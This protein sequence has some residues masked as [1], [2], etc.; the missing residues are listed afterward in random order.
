MPSMKRSALTRA[1][2]R[3]IFGYRGHS[4]WTA[5]PGVDTENDASDEEAEGWIKVPYTPPEH[6]APMP[7][8]KEELANHTLIRAPKGAI[9]AIVRKP[10]ATAVAVIVFDPLF[11]FLP[12]SVTRTISICF[13]LVERALTPILDWMVTQMDIL[14]VRSL[15]HSSRLAIKMLRMLVMKFLSLPWLKI[16]LGPRY[17]RTV[18]HVLGRIAVLP[19]EGILLYCAYYLRTSANRD[20]RL[21][22]RVQSV[23]QAERLREPPEPEYEIIP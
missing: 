13:D 20:R 14:G 11:E 4:K 16:I 17:F 15:W 7:C 21:V 8:L 10:N 19:W 18:L 6:C 2:K 22:L 5:K 23:Y 3:R 9:D 12:Q 1:F